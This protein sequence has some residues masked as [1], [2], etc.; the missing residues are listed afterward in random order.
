MTVFTIGYEGLDIDTFMSL[1]G[2]HGIE[3]IVDIRELLLSRK[4]GFSKRALG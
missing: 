1:L 3:T 4:R 2:Q